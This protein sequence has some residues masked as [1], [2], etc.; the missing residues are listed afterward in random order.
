MKASV[1]SK[2]AD[3]N[4]RLEA[5]QAQ[6]ARNYAD[7]DEVN[8][9][10]ETLNGL[11]QRRTELQGRAQRKCQ[12]NE[13]REE[14]EN[15]MAV[16][17]RDIEELEVRLAGLVESLAGLGMA[18]DETVAEG[19]RAAEERSRKAG[20]LEA[21]QGRMGE[22]GRASRAYEEEEAGRLVEARRSLKRIEGRSGREE[23]VGT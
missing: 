17:R 10:R 22:L 7:Q 19:R 16:A 13:K 6:V 5:V 8:K 12:M 20:G 9:L 14:L 4:R 2:L 21:A 23:V 11:R 15:E 18:R 1:Q 3:V